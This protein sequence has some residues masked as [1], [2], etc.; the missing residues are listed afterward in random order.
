MTVAS[1]TTPRKAGSH[2]AKPRRLVSVAFIR[3]LLDLSQSTVYEW[4]HNGKLPGAVKV[5]SR[6]RFDLDVIEAWLDA[7]GDFS[8]RKQK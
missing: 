6:V 8:T 7:G 4:A 5:G 2:P 1:S 3:E